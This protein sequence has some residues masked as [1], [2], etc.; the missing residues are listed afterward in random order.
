[1][2]ILIKPITPDDYPYVIESHEKWRSIK[3]DYKELTLEEISKVHQNP[4]FRGFIAWI[5]DRRVGRIAGLA[6][7][8]NFNVGS[9]WVDEDYRRRGVAT[10]LLKKL[11]RYH[12]P[13]TPTRIAIHKRNPLYAQLRKFYGKFGFTRVIK[14]SE[15]LLML[16][17]PPLTQ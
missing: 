11:F 3:P 16:G 9:L 13:G 17:S 10:L 4:D 2:E 5:G 7:A 6:D 14:E 15:N 12:Q 8:K 1:M